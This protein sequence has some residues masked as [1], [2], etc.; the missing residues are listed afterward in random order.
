MH[1]DWVYATNGKSGGGCEW[2]WVL[3]CL[4]RKIWEDEDGVSMTGGFSGDF[5]GSE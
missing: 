2:L 4:G 3:R 5:L 1:C